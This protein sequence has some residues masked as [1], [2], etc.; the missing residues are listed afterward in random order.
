MTPDASSQPSDS[1]S[2]ESTLPALL[3]PI[4]SELPLLDELLLL[5]DQTAPVYHG[6]APADSAA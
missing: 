6:E 1:C 3:A 5:A 2:A 4:L